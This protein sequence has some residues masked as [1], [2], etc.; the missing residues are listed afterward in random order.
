LAIGLTLC[1]YVAFE[2][3]TR[4]VTI[5]GS[6]LGFRG[7]SFPF[8]PPPFCVF[9]P[10]IGGQ[11]RGTVELSATRLQTD[12]EVFSLQ[13]PLQFPDRFTEVRVL[14]RLANFVFPA[15]G[16]YL[17]TLLVDGEW[18]AQRRISVTQTGGTA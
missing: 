15:P 4:N 9:A 16:V 17:F 3:G 18:M 6:F 14:F 1:H 8:T 11:G 12:T 5:A 13:R 7:A 10:L 2:E